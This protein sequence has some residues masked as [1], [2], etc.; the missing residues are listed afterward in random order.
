MKTSYDDRV[1]RLGIEVENLKQNVKKKKENNSKLAEGIKNLRDT[2]FAFV[3]RCS[4]RLCE[5]L[6]SVIV[7]L[8]E[9]IYAPMIYVEC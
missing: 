5:I 7:A 2:C 4:M 1:S 6:H 8:D 9:V 3:A